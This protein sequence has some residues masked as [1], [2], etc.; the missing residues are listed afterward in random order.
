MPDTHFFY[1]QNSHF[2]LAQKVTNFAF[3]CVALMYKMCIGGAAMKLQ[4][5]RRACWN[6]RCWKAESSEIIISLAGLIN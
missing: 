3:A 2:F 1:L 4:N 6:T 5:V